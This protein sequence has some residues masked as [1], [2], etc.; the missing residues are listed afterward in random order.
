MERIAKIAD[1]AD[2]IVNGYAFTCKDNS[3]YVLNLNNP[4]KA[5]V[6]LDG[7]LSET[8]MDDIELEIVSDY[9]KRNEKFLEARDA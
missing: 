7:E 1:E 8:S 6:F 3:V 9:L 5:A 4:D 2:I